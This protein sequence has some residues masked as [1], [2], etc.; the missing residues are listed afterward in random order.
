[1]GRL[2]F[3]ALA[4]SLVLTGCSTVRAYVAEIDESRAKEFC[5]AQRSNPDITLLS[6]KV[7]FVSPD[8]IT[9]VMLALAS[10]PSP[11]EADAIKL[12]AQDQHACRERM[13]KVAKDHWPTQNAMRK[14]LAMKLDLVTAQLINRKITYGNANR[15]YQ[16]AA[17]EA[18]GALTADRKEQLDKVREQEAIAWRTVG[19][20]IRAIAG[21]QK[22]EAEP[23]PCNWSGTTMDCGGQ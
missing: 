11:Q 9:P 23:E 20:G 18:E 16:E 19:D 2:I 22:P 10:V 3:A 14:A 5:E 6:G 17:L 15:L 12:L 1:M 8:E 21:S 4:T 13:D 7:P